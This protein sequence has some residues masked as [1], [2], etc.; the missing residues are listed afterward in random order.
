[1]N[2]KIPL[3]AFV[4]ALLA[5]TKFTFSQSE[6]LK[7]E[8]LNAFTFRNIGPAVASGRIIDLAVNPKNTSEYYVGV[9]CG[10]VWKTEN[11]GVTFKPIFDQY[12]YFSIGCLALDPQNP[13]TIWV[14][15]GENNNQRSVSYGNGVYVSRNGGKSFEHMGL[16]SSEHIGMIKIHPHHSEIVYVAA[17]G[18]LWKSGGE[19]GVY[20]SID[21]GKNWKQIHQ[22]S[23]HTGCNEIHIDPKNPQILYATYHQRRRHEWTYLGGGPESGIYK[24]TDGGE[25]WKKLTYGLPTGEVGRITLG[26]GQ[27][28]E[29]IYAM[30]EGE[31]GGIYVSTDQG[32]SWEKKSESQTAGN[33]YQELFVD[34]VDDDRIFIM[35]TWLKW[36]KDGGKTVVPVGE[37][38][39]HVDN[40]VIWINPTNN[41]HWLVGCDGGL[42]ETWDEGKNWQFKPNLPVTQFYRVAVDNTE[43][44]YYVYGGTQDNNT[45]GGPIGSIN[46]HGVSN[47]DWFVT[48]GGDGFKSQVDPKDPNTVYSQWQYGGLI[49]YDRNTGEKVDIKPTPLSTEKALRWNWDAPLLISKHHSN[50]LYFAANKVYK[51]ED[52]GNSW[53]AISE[54][55]TRQIDRN[56]LPVMD[57]VWGMDAVAKNQSTS[58]YGNIIYMAESPLDEKILFAGTDDGWV[59]ISTDGGKTWNKASIP[60]GLPDMAAVS[61]IVASEF[62]ANVVYVGFDN[63]RMGDFK[64]YLFKSKD[65]GKTWVSMVGNLPQ[66]ATIKSMA[67][68]FVKKE[69][70]F[71]GTEFGLYASIDGGKSWTQWTSG[72]PPI[73]IKDIVIQKKSCDLVLATFGRGIAI[74]D[75]YAPI[76]DLTG[77]AMNEEGHLFQIKNAWSYI[78][79]TPL[80]NRG[81]SH[82]GE[83][84]Y[85]SPNPEFGANII[86]HLKSDYKT[87]KENRLA[88]E[89]DQKSKNLPIKYPSADSIRQEDRDKEPFL[90]FIIKNA[91]GLEV[92]R[93]VAPAKKGIGKINWNL[94]YASSSPLTFKEPDLSNPYAEP[95]WGP[96]VPAGTYSVSMYLVKRET[97]TALGTTVNF[98]V[99][100]LYPE[101]NQGVSAE[102]R[103]R[104]I[105]QTAELKRNI[106]AASEWY[107]QKSQELLAVEKSI[108]KSNANAEILKTIWSIKSQMDVLYLS[109]YGDESLARRE[110]EV[111]SGIYETIENVHYALVSSTSTPTQTHL[112]SLDD[113]KVNF[114]QWIEKARVLEGAFIQLEKQ[115]DDLKIPYSPGRSFFLK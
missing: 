20:K 99:I 106:N 75:N 1:M 4:I 18:P 38:S 74:L 85:T 110:F 112:K 71:L 8:W 60:A 41:K 48:V 29:K 73:A 115:L 45:L 84:Y 56:K 5:T 32:E 105:R 80:G 17:Y 81:K 63:H 78:Q 76:R 16:P 37:K 111:L 7:S 97:I 62:D 10:G 9:A 67:E 54:D 28:G 72:L 114:Q 11:A 30:I 109:L 13:N 3:F 94:R 65:L 24:S 50:R 6:T 82:Q 55:L 83:S 64:P 33:Y 70:L 104:C 90:L 53:E 22:V 42:Y 15:T 79:P 103:D 47:S 96:L 12:K 102:V 107:K 43:P 40:H 35:D 58:I 68:D 36:S 46:G 88:I 19:R 108:Q 52:K 34:P 87:I 25:T 89:Q 113:V 101:S 69:L 31:K 95:D 27:H 77:P 23:V 2:R 26:L 98:E 66:D 86:Y 91:A 100:S 61:T 44:F 39:K 49:R 21:G 14:G 57:K 92:N 51:S 93:I 59:Q